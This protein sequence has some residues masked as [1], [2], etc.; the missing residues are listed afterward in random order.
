VVTLV[1]GAIPDI[2]I[3]LTADVDDF[4]RD[5]ERAADAAER[6]AARIRAA[7]A[8]A[9]NGP[10]GGGNDDTTRRMRDLNAE[11]E[12][13]T[14]AARNAA[15][16]I[17]DHG[18]S[19]RRAGEDVESLRRRLNELENG[20]G[21]VGSAGASAGGGIG[22]MGKV[23]LVLASLLPGVIAGLFALGAAAVGVAAA[24]GVMALG[25]KGLGQAFDG[26]ER[27][28]QPLKRQLDSVFRA[29]LS[30]EMIKLG[31]T[32]STQ[33]AP[34]FKEV[35]KAI[36]EVIKDTSE[37][38]RSS[39]GIQT[40]KTMMGGVADLVRELGPA[41]KGI[42]QIFVEFGAAAAP[43]MGKIGA[44]IS[45]VITGLR[46]M[47]REAQKSGQLQRIFE[48]GAEAIKGFGE[49]V[50]GLIMILMEMAD[51]G[52]KPAAEAMKDLGK[53]LQN[54]APA[55]GAVFRGLAQAAEV[56]AK[57]IE[58]VSRL[59][60]AFKGTGGDIGAFVALFMAVGPVLGSI[61]APIKMIADLF[62]KAGKE[63]EKFATNFKKGL[64]KVALEIAKF[65]AKAGMDIAKWA[66]KLVTDA[67]Q[68]V[69]K[70][71]AAVK[72]GFDK[73][74]QA[75][76]QAM[77][78]VNQSIKQG[79][80]KVSAP[81]TQGLAKM[82]AAVKQGF[83]KANQEITQAVDRM[84]QSARE[85]WDKMVAAIG[86]GLDRANQA[87]KDGIDKIVQGFKSMT[88]QFVR[89]GTEMVEGLIKGAKAKVDELVNTF[90]QMA[91]AALAAAKAALGI[92]SPSKLFAD[93]VGA[94]IPTGIA[95][96]ITAGTP[97]LQAALARTMR[98]LPM[99]ANVALAGASRGAAIGLG[100]GTGKQVI[101]V[102]LDVGSGGDGAAGAMISGLARRGQLKLTANAIV[103]GRR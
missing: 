18:N 44:A 33:L 41:V 98:T 53:A 82:N 84:V 66:T 89:A 83:D 85:W 48:A 75:V 51:Q 93:E 50:K 97:A 90:K 79:W 40:I 2:V 43:A 34:S 22:S 3:R 30:Q 76:K 42:V 59:G 9:G 86:Q 15:D 78:K 23:L 71:A 54:A 100:T 45:E 73:A 69:D 92:H 87:I 14:R 24:A 6:A 49:I 27:T 52:G 58:F 81:V 74:N 70:F 55:I 39:E 11:L 68:G 56:I 10:G 96:G 13:M 99:T 67:K 103:G 12:R 62:P 46:D 32:I 19:S 102:K 26:L 36:S 80:D 31:Q 38:I 37:W 95:Q 5:W 72:Q 29:Q 64:D 47:F 17:R 4:I 88:D 65:V 91:E 28:I 94:H 77:D 61:I 35:A 20:L 16:A 57:V 63:I 1:A 101:E 60:K 8:A 7:G 21:R 25:A